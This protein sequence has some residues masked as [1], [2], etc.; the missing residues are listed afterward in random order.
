MEKGRRMTRGNVLRS[1]GTEQEKVIS[2]CYYHEP[3]YPDL[4]WIYHC[5]N[6]GSRNKTEAVN[7]KRQGVK[8][9][10]P[11][12]HL[13]VSR[14]RYIGLY[15]ELKYNKGRLQPSQIEWLNGLQ[16]AGHFTCTCYGFDNAIKIIEEYINLS[17]DTE[18][19]VPN[20]AILK[21]EGN[22]IV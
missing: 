7:L 22:G 21:Q 17:A 4:K 1:E 18:M 5:P 6:G 14:S 13:P 2:W 12:L 8:S 10:V 9:G 3:Q 19:S 20:G 15:I 11:D 16:A